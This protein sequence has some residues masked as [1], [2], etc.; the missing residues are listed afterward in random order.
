MFSHTQHINR[1]RRI[2]VRCLAACTLAALPMGAALISNAFDTT[3]ATR[4]EQARPEPSG[5]L[6]GSHGELG[7]C[8]ETTCRPQQSPNDP[9]TP[10]EPEVEFL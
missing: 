1:V 8:T 7:Q 9:S 5:E 6:G 4:L 10:D 2:A 3:P